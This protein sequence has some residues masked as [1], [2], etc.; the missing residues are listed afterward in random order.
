MVAAMRSA[1]LSQPGILRVETA[2]AE[3]DSGGENVGGMDLPAAHG[4]CGEESRYLTG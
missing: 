2:D 4:E 1:K 3:A